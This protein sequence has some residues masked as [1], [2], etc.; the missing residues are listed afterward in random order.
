MDSR[1]MGAAP[2]GPFI[3][4]P[5]ATSLQLMPLIRRPLILLPLYTPGRCARQEEDIA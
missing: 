1:V 5:T 2:A 4:L 3:A